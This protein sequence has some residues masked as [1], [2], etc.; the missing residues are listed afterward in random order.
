MYSCYVCGEL[1]EEWDLH[2]FYSGLDK[3]KDK[4]KC[5]FTVKGEEE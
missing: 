3:C 4:E 2:R 1:K 5:S